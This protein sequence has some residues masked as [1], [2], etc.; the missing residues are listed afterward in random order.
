MIEYEIIIITLSQDSCLPV[1]IPDINFWEA[2]RMYRR[3][4]ERNADIPYFHDVL[5]LY[6]FTFGAIPDDDSFTQSHA[7]CLHQLSS[8]L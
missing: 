3:N 2:S 7:I 5:W 6:V 8:V 1:S 4:M